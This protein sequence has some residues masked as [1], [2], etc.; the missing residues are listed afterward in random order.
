MLVAATAAALNV[1]VCGSEKLPSLEEHVQFIL[2]SGAWELVLGHEAHPKPTRRSRT[3]RAALVLA[4]RFK[5]QRFLRRRPRGRDVDAASAGEPRL[6][7][8]PLQSLVDGSEPARR[9]A[10]ALRK[11][12]SGH[13]M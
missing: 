7:L 11:V 4:L 8:Q 9:E 5:S 2:L 12:E 6:V 3:V 10:I 1:S 13:H